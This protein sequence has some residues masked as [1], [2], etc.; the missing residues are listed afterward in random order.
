ELIEEFSRCL[1]KVLRRDPPKPIRKKSGA[2]MVKVESKALYELL[3]KPIDIN[4]IA[5]YVEHC[6]ECMRRFARSFFDS[7][8][9]VG[10]DGRIYC[11]NT[12]IQLLQYVRRILNLLG[13]RTTEPKIIKKKGTT[14]F[15]RRNGKTYTRRKNVYYIHVIASDRLR[16][17]QLIG[18]TIQR[19]QKRLEEYLKKHGL[20]TT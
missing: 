5:P 15:D 4:K 2:F 19:K 6:E 7:E 16:F 12:D 9:G 20:L 14:I 13:I 17:Y 8:G 1:G 18:F 3:K 11:Y 10:K